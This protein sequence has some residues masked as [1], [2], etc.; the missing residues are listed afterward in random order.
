[1]LLTVQV[2][3]LSSPF[4]AF[5]PGGMNVNAEGSFCAGQVLFRCSPQRRLLPGSSCEDLAFTFLFVS[6]KFYRTP[7]VVHRAKKLHICASQKGER[8]AVC[9]ARCL[10]TYSARVLRKFQKSP[11]WG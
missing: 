3:L 8:Q 1:M 9:C 10:L 2:A 5:L 11:S 6:P 4:V 7:L